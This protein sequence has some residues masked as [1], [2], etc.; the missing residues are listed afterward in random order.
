MLIL[1]TIV[2]IRHLYMSFLHRRTLAFVRWPIQMFCLS[3]ALPYLDETSSDIVLWHP[4][5]TPIVGK[6]NPSRKFACISR[7]TLLCL[8]RRWHGCPSQIVLPSCVVGCTRQIRLYAVRKAVPP[9][10]CVSVNPGQRGKRNLQFVW[11]SN[12]VHISIDAQ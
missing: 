6:L 11:T 4:N 8:C 9:A 1:H 2:S 7:G 10:R 5:R 12:F 3:P